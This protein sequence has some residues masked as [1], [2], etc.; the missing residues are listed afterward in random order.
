MRGVHSTWRNSN[1]FRLKAL[2]QRMFDVAGSETAGNAQ[3]VVIGSDGQA[4]P[5]QSCAPGGEALA[6]GVCAPS[7]FYDTYCYTGV[8]V[9]PTAMSTDK[10]DAFDDLAI[11]SDAF[12]DRTHEDGGDDIE[13][14]VTSTGE[15]TL[16]NMRE[17]VERFMITDINN[18]AGS[19]KAQ[20]DILLLRDEAFVDGY[21]PVTGATDEVYEFNHIPGGVNVLFM[22]GHVE[23]IRYPGELATRT[24][25]LTPENM[26]NSSW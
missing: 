21:D 19:A 20:S 5:D 17:G 8:V 4:K 6:A 14:V 23:F 22:D 16:F 3:D 18:P 26:N 25:F 1:H 2:G 15:W 10:V 9:P 11:L 7:F 13:E 24:W 12:Y